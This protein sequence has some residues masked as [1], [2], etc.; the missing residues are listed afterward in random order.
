MIHLSPLWGFI[1][2]TN[3]NLGY[4]ANLLHSQKGRV[5]DENHDDIL[6]AFGFVFTER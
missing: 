3:G 5:S 4:Y 1:H 2:D 6:Y